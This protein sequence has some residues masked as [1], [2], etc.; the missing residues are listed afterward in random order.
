[1]KNEKAFEI[2]DIAKTEMKA[3][4]LRASSNFRVRAGVRAG[5]TCSGGCADDCGGGGGSVAMV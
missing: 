1:M 4:Q 3:E 5:D 2:R